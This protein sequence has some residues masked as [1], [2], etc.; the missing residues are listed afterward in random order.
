MLG[1]KRVFDFIYL[2]QLFG[3]KVMGDG[4]QSSRTVTRVVVSRTRASVRHT[5]AQFR[6]VLQNL[7]G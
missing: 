5:L 2:L 1:N 7:K 6:R 3:I 4:D